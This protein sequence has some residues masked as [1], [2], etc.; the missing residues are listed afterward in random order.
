MSQLTKVAKHLRANSKTGPGITARKL[1]SLARCPVTSVHK[2]IYDLRVNEG[3]E[4]YTNSRIVN[5]Q[6][7]YFYRIAS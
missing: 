2:R 4:I 7:K 1:A 3:K 5:G 6:R